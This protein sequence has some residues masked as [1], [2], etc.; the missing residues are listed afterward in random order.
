M[1]AGANAA[2]RAREEEGLVLARS[3]AY[4][5]VLVDDLI[6]QGTHEP[7]RMFSSRAEYRL[8]L[9]HD[10]ADQR[11]TPLGRRL[12]LVNDAR[13]AAFEAKREA[14]ERGRA[15]FAKDTARTK[16]MRRHGATLAEVAADLPEVLALPSEVRRLLE[17]E[18]R[19]AGYIER[20]AARVQRH[21]ELEDLRLPDDVDYTTL[22][23][24]RLEA[25]EKL[26]TI[27]P[28]SVGQATRISGVTPADVSVLLIY[29]S[30]WGLD[31]P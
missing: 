26:Q 17:V 31:T 2:L 29:L 7:Y 12:G 21:R 10:N 14:L 23:E 15:V 9:R 5:G 28:E 27:R 18:L 20:E 24:L 8:L 30:K 11:L 4:M 22:P 3:E 25:R 6:T 16:A 1:I 19:Y 13:W